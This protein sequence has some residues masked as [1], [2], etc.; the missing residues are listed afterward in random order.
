M[1]LMGFSVNI[2]VIRFSISHDLAYV[3]VLGLGFSFFFT[4]RGLGLFLGTGF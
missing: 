4:V 1:G 2:R 3:M